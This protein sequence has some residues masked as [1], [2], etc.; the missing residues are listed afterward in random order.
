MYATSW[1]N[2]FPAW[3]IDVLLQTNLHGNCSLIYLCQCE[4]APKV[5]CVLV[6]VKVLFA[7][8]AELRRMRERI[9]LIEA[10][11]ARSKQSTDHPSSETLL[12]ASQLSTESVME[13]SCVSQTCQSVSH[14]P[15]RLNKT[16]VQTSSTVDTNCSGSTCSLSTPKAPVPGTLAVSSLSVLIAV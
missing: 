12:P 2:F 4:T 14:K 11:L 5:V 8:L 16:V 3:I 15:E 13:Q 10:K 7:V 9:S 1:C 6:V